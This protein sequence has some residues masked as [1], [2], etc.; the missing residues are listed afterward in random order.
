MLK[1]Y[2]AIPPQITIHIILTAPSDC[3]NANVFVYTELMG[4]FFYCYIIKVT[5]VDNLA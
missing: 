5:D 3:A 2:W 1:I 4:L